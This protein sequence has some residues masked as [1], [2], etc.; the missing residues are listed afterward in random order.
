MTF[1]AHTRWG[2]SSRQPRCIFRIHIYL[3]VYEVR[4]RLTVSEEKGIQV[5]I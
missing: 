1:Q 5:E 4:C 2:D 3:H